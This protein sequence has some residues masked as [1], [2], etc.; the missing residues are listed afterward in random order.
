MSHLFKPEWLSE[1]EEFGFQRSLNGTAIAEL[2]NKTASKYCEKISREMRTQTQTV[3]IVV[4]TF[5]VI[6]RRTAIMS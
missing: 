1:S 5:N 2:F 3:I 6:L 4:T